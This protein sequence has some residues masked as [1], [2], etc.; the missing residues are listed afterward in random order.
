MTQHEINNIEAT[1]ILEESIENPDP[2]KVDRF[3]ETLLADIA[4]SDKTETSPCGGVK[5]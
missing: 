5:K 1:M 4:C 3:L 2:Q